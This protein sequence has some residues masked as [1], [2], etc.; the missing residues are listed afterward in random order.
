L[1]LTGTTIVASLGTSAYT[2]AAGNNGSSDV[3]VDFKVDVVAPELLS[4]DRTKPVANS[5]E[6]N[7]IDMVFSEPVFN[8]TNAGFAVLRGTKSATTTTSL[9]APLVQA[10]GNT[11]DTFKVTGI[12]QAN[13]RAGGNYAFSIPAGSTIIDEAGNKAVVSEAVGSWSQVDV[14]ARAK[15]TSTLPSLTNNTVLPITVSFGR[16]MKNLTAAGIVVLNDNNQIVPVNIPTITRSAD[17]KKFTFNV[18]LGSNAPMF[19]M[20]NFKISVADGAAVTNDTEELPCAFSESRV[21]TIDRI[22]P[23]GTLIPWAGQFTD[24]GNTN[25]NSIDYKA[26][27]ELPVQNV[28]RS[29]I[30]VTGGTVT[31]VFA[32][33]GTNLKEWRVTVKPALNGTATQNVAAQLSTGIFKDPAGNVNLPSNIV[34]VAI[35]RNLAITS[36]I[37]VGTNQASGYNFAVGKLNNLSVRF[38]DVVDTSTITAAAFNVAGGTVTNIRPDPDSKGAQ[39][40]LVFA[41]RPNSQFVMSVAFK[42]GV[43]HDLFGNIALSSTAKAWT[44][45]GLPPTAIMTGAARIRLG[46]TASVAIKFSENVQ[47]LNLSMFV[48]TFTPLN[49]GATVT[50]SNS[51]LL[52]R[53]ASA[54]WSISHKSAVRGTLTVRLKIDADGP[55]DL[56]GNAVQIP[57]G[58]QVVIA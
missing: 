44:I 52:L 1:D 45:D 58:Y 33:A 29:M 19:F 16:A 53:G 46:E 42:A 38:N 56:L 23:T 51:A 49:G 47:P 24:G 25:R 5:E 15:I 9:G 11:G 10:V 17:G 14:D 12:T 34:T 36:T 7:R 39:F 30:T 26:I 13:T 37:N 2:D 22:P 50:L 54:S 43:V 41:N 21:F 18:E 32:I 6:F 35:K 8:V 55:K 27:F 48:V 3:S 20:G 28:P 4:A 57:V 40:D 31:S